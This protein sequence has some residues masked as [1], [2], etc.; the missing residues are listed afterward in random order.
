MKLIDQ[1][2][3]AYKK[4]AYKERE[5]IVSTDYFKQCHSLSPRHS[6]T[7]PVGCPGTLG[8][9]TRDHCLCHVTRSCGGC[10]PT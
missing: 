2:R 7:L 1:L 3:V 4:R 9:G 6:S 8:P 10:W 5:R